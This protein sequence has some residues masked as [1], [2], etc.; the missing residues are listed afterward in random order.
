MTKELLT[1]LYS[2]DPEFVRTYHGMSGMTIESAAEDTYGAIKYSNS[3][4]YDF[5]YFTTDF[6][7]DVFPRLTGFFIKPEFRNKDTYKLFYKELCSKMPPL[8]MSCIN[9]EN[10]RAINF[11]IKCGGTI[12]SKQDNITYLFFKQEIS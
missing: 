9:D 10:E 8:F 11:L 5:G 4:V 6:T 7:Q 3:Y 2:T 12:M 1:E